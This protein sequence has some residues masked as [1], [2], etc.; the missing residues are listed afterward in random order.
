MDQQYNRPQTQVPQQDG[1]DIMELLFLCLAKWKWFLL[2]VV[3]CLGLASLHILRTAPV[4]T[5]SATLLIKD[6]KKG[7]A[8]A[9]DIGDAFANMGFNAARTNINNELL[10]ISSPANILDVVKRLNLDINYRTKGFFH[11]Y[12]LYGTSLPVNVSLL[13]IDDRQGA[14]FTLDVMGDRSYSVSDLVTKGEKVSGSWQGHFGDT[15]STP[16]GRFT[17][18]ETPAFDPEKESQQ[19]LV[20]RSSL[21]NTVRSCNARLTVALT[22]KL[23]TILGITYQDVST[24]R[25]DDFINTLISVYN[26]N[27]VKDRNQIA[28]STSLFI[29]DR[30]AVIERELGN[31]DGDISSYKSEHLIPDIAAASNMYMNQASKAEATVVELSNEA[32]MARYI[33]NYLTSEQNVNSLLPSNAGISNT[34]INQQIGEYN[35]KLL[36]RSSLVANSSETNPLVVD[37]DAQLKSLRSAIVTSIDNELVTIEAQISSQKSYGNR[38]TSQIANNP[39]QAKYLLSVERQQK[40]KESLYLF[41]LQKREENELGQ[42]FTAYNSRIITPPYGSDYPTS[43]SKSKILLVALILG[44]AIPFGWIYVEQMLNTKIRGR[45][46][47]EDRVS[48]PFLGEIPQYFADGDK[49]RI[50]EINHKKK[51]YNTKNRIV[52]NS[53]RSMDYIN[54]A[55]RVMRTNVGFVLGGEQNVAIIT[56]YNPGSG[57][58]FIINNLA[59]CFALKNKKIL[60]IDCDLR[61]AT[62]SKYYTNTKLGLSSYLAGSVDNVEDIMIHPDDQ[63]TLTVIPVGAV[64]PNPSE[65]ISDDKFPQLIER[66]RKEYDLI[67]LDCPPVEIVADTMIIE[68][69]ADRTLFVIRAGLFERSMLKNLEADYQSGRFK[70]MSLILNGTEAQG[71]YGGYGYR[72]GYNYGYGSYEYGKQS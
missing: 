3:V 33:R 31:V 2:S 39:D 48:M 29:D 23:A 28:I 61:K 37:I 25:A 43:P 18:V 62:T 7:N 22:D 64:P 45:K 50:L 44:L 35:E 24:Q 47:L 46:D 55:F 60:L 38:A 40:V 67:L 5:R 19:I 65:L 57:K 53:S 66:F 58:S 27:W 12:T 10:S 51:L 56:S 8:I 41:L 1:P 17:V 11:D 26:E 15:L 54:E 6:D 71:H 59:A 30:L 13:D 9:S 4:Y 32:Y 34:A 69:V 14:S 68:K 70:N 36:R 49:K 63:P 20:S 21:N 42:A 72:Y 52:V 16:L